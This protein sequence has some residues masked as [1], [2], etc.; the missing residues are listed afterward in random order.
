MQAST[1]CSEEVLSQTSDY[2]IPNPSLLPIDPDDLTYDVADERQWCAIAAVP[3]LDASVNQPLQSSVP[4]LVFSGRY[5]PIT[6]AQFGDAVLA[7]LPNSRHIVFARTA[8]GSFVSNACAGQIAVAFLDNPQSN[9][10]ALSSVCDI[11][12]KAT[13]ATSQT[14]RQGTFISQIM[15]LAPAVMPWFYLIIAVSCLLSSVLV[16]RPLKMLYKIIRGIYTP[17]IV[18]QLHWAELIT[19]LSAL[20]IVGYL[21]YIGVDS[22]L[23]ADSY[24]M[25]FGIS[26]SYGALSGL[27]Y[28][29]PLT[30]FV[31]WYAMYRLYTT[32]STHL[33]DIPTQPTAHATWLTYVY[34][35]IILLSSVV[36]LATLLFNGIYGGWP[37]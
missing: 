22:S 20:G 30:I 11:N 36:L 28:S 18:Q 37:W 10:T 14:I 29:L 21:S 6:P 9:G 27:L 33:A 26:T 16:W 13:F 3:Q 12:Q 7:G 19:T 24:G 17:S 1:I 35:G 23:N 25:L 34:A 5:D 31:L 8:H 15:Q 4:T 2:Q 32:P